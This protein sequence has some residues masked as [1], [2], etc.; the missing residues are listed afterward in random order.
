VR[1][2]VSRGVKEEMNILQTTK[3]RKADWIGHFSRTNCLLKDKIKG[4]IKVTGK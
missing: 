1:N 3:R 4:R 2:E